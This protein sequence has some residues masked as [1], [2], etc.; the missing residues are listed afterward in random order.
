MQKRD[1]PDLDMCMHR[2]FEGL[3]EPF[4]NSEFLRSGVRAK[5]AIHLLMPVCAL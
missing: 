2:G 3:R 1:Q 5:R 4:H